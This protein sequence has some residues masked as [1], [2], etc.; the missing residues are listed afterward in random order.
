[1][2][3]KVETPH[4]VEPYE[5]ATKEEARDYCIGMLS[6]SGTKWRIFRAPSVAVA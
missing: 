6:W 3:W 2:V 4:G 1:M 5:F